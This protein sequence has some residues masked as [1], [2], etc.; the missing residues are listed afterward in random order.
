MAI[1]VC[2]AGSSDDGCFKR[3]APIENRGVL[4]KIFSDDSTYAII[5]AHY[6]IVPSVC[7]STPSHFYAWTQD[8][9]FVLMM[10]TL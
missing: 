7:I 2:Y 4:G 10:L 8:M 3:A 5:M 6:V 1:S 9:C